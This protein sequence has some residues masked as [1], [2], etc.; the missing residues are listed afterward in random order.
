MADF[1]NIEKKVK[2]LRTLYRAPEDKPIIDNVEKQLRRNLAKAQIVEI[3]EIQELVRATQKKI[4]DINLMLQWDRELTNDER[5]R[6]MDE[7]KIHLFWIERLDPGKAS[8]IISELE[9]FVDK[10]I[11]EASAL[12]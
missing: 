4:D 3:A 2:E 9:T 10:K 12:E 8:S 5:L 7:R 1:N 6:L 11:T